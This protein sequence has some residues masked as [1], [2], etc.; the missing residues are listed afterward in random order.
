MPTVTTDDDSELYYEWTDDA[1]GP[2]VV[3][4]NGMTQSTQNW[5]SQVKHFRDD[6]RVLTYDARC[7]GR[8]EVDPSPPTMERH[9]R[10]LETLLDAVDVRTIHVV[11]FS[12]GARLALGFAA[13]RPNRTRR[14]VLC[15]L[16]SSPTAL[17]RTIV[18]S[19]RET[20]AAGGLEAMAWTALPA[21]LG[22]DFLEQNEHILDGIVRASLR[23][24]T[25]QGV[26]TLLEAME[27]YPAL[28]DLARDVDARTLVLSAQEDLL[29]DTDGAEELADLTGGR[30]S[31]IDGCGH[32]IPIERPDAFHSRVSSFLQSDPS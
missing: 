6:F 7:Q 14:L 23:R 19:W 26:R 20:L 3:F 16:S 12:H 13:R 18:R 5:S 8:S 22:D 4:L 15:S 21:I 32:T 10:D 25:E 9:V 31:Q 29:V 27:D 17:A 2:A 24:N 30:H 11:G 1:D 28:T